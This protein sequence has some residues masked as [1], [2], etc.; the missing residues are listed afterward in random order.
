[1]KIA[2]SDR[3]IWIKGNDDIAGGLLG[4]VDYMSPEMFECYY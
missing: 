3:T 4:V 1:M 2:A